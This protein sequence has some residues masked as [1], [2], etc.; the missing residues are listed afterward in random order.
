MVTAG[1]GGHEL[2][3]V[4]TV[5]RVVVHAG[6]QTRQSENERSTEK[7]IEEEAGAM[8]MADRILV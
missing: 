8:K 3:T 5:L 2:G 4:G 6:P 1:G 7:Y